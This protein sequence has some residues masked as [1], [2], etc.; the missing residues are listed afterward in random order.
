M[1]SERDKRQRRG[2]PMILRSCHAQMKST[3]D[4]R[5][6]KNGRN[7]RNGRNEESARE[8]LGSVTAVGMERLGSV[9]ELRGI[10]SWSRGNIYVSHIR[11]K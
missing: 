6:E 3:R 9:A 8:S 11:I 5:N 1:R 4:E 2:S 7:G 10:D